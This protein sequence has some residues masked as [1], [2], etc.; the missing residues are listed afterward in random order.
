MGLERFQLR[1]DVLRTAAA[2]TRRRFAT[3][4]LATAAIVAFVWA[5]ALRPRGAGWGTLAFSLGLLVALAAF[6]LGRRMRRLHERFRSFEIAL[7]GDAI[8]RE[9]AGFPPLRIARAEVV[10]IGERADGIVVRAQGGAAILVPR[11]LD[12][13]ARVREALAG[14]RRGDA[15]TST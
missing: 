5:A 15:E 14:W 7:E 13:Y 10:E 8:S 2:R 4:L 6:S 3:T 12:G 11:E 9:V 1:A